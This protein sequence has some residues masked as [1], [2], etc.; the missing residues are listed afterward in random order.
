MELTDEEINVRVAEVLGWT[1]IDNMYGVL[2]GVPAEGHIDE[3]PDEI[4]YASSLDACAE[5]E[6]TLTDEE[7]A[8]FRNELFRLAYVGEG[9][10]SLSAERGRVSAPAKTR[11]MAFLKVKGVL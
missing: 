8:R 11:C 10:T 3:P 7:H 5:M 4:R 9:S 1:D 2:H 6:A